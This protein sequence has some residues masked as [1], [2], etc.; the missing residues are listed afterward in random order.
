MVG[1]DKFADE[2][3]LKCTYLPICDGGC[4][5]YRVGKLEKNL[6]YNVCDIN[7]KGLIKY[8]ETYSEAL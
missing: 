2:K 1:T 7:E 6:P 4:N 3:C 5:L 8:L